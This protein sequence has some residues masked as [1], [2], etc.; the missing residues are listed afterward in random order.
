MNG[1]TQFLKR[2]GDVAKNKHVLTGGASAG[3]TAIALAVTQFFVTL[4]QDRSSSVNWN[5]KQS[6]QIADLQDRLA[7]AE[8]KLDVIFGNTR[9]KTDLPKGPE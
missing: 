8:T 7:R 6:E 1:E 2:I 3:V 5:R 9:K 4:N